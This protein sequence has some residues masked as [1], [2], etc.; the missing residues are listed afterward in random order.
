[1]S[2]VSQ[3]TLFRWTYVNEALINIHENACWST[4]GPQNGDGGGSHPIEAL[5]PLTSHITHVYL[6]IN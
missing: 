1:M 3:E 5:Y 2:Y 4:K 6:R